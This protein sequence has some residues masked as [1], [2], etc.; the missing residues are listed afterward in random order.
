MTSQTR[1]VGLVAA[2][3]LAVS[4]CGANDPYAVDTA[5]PT[6]P[7][8]AARTVTSAPPSGALTPAEINRQDHES[9]ALVRRQ[10]AATSSRPML[11]ALPISTRGVTIAIAGLD[12]DGRTTILELR[13]PRGRAHAL[14]VY[15]RELRRY[16][17]NGHAYRPVF[18]R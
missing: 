4:A 3:A 15:L 9:P 12:A 2:V 10:Q 17:D 11:S 14:A 6:T 8:A 5:P 7:N 1:G 18:T 16:G 13:A